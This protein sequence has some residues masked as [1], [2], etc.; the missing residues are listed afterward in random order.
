MADA[1]RYAKIIRYARMKRSV[2]SSEEKG[3]DDDQLLFLV[4]EVEQAIL[5]YCNI[6]QVPKELEFVWASMTVD[7]ALYMIES[8]YA[9]KDPMDAL[10]P[11]DLSSIKVGDVSVFV[12]DKYRSNERSRT[13]Q[14]HNANLDDIVYNYREQLNHFRRLP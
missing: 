1:Q 4:Q 5:N 3:L 13:L 10:D 7:S 14:S 6:C 2:I 11:S 8:N 12:G 9:P